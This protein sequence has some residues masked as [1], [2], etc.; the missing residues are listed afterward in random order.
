M[1]L[2]PIDPYRLHLWR[3]FLYSLASGLIWTT[4]T[5]FSIT[6]V[7]MTPFQLVIVGSALELT[8]FICEVPTGIVADLYSRRLSVII[9]FF[10]VGIAYALMVVPAFL[11]MFIGH[12]IWGVGWTFISG[13][14]DAWLVDEIG[15]ERAGQAFLRGEQVG[16]IGT[17]IGIGGSALLATIALQLPMILGATIIIGIGVLLFF[18]MPETGFKPVERPEQSTLQKMRATFVEGFTV[19]R[20][21]P[22]LIRILG[23]GLF[24]GLFS[25]A[26]DRLWQAH[27]LET[28]SVGA[29]TFVTPVTFI[30][31]LNL[32]QL[33]LAVSGAE[34]LRRRI[35]STNPRRLTDTIMVLTTIMVAALLV[36]GLAPHVAVA[37]LAFFAFTISRNLIHPLFNTW[38]NGQITTPQVRATVLSMSGQMDAIGQ[39]AGGPPLGAIGTYSLRA[40]F[41]ASSALLAP[42]LPLLYGARKTPVEPPTEVIPAPIEP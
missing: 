28:F 36:Y 33:F 37:L 34:Y 30:A 4:L 5:V 2:R 21:K 31:G 14:Y 19:V 27:L 26:W 15:I 16:R 1:V 3:I 13:A 41:V 12:I 17:A 29:I 23:V 35:D 20:G 18:T 6:V 8:I 10:V 39:L 7:G 24:F 22:T 40:A 9:G 42:A 11:A 25:E 38:I 32:I